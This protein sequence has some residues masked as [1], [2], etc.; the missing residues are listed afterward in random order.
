MKWIFLS[1]AA[2][3]STST[4]ATE[5]D[6][7][8]SGQPEI[9]CGP[10]S[11]LVNFNTL[12][13][14]EG[15]VYVK[16]FY[17]TPGCRTEA[18]NNRAATIS[19]P[20]SNCG[21]RRERSANPL[22][23]YVGTTVVISFHPQFV[24]KVDRAYNVRCFY[25][26]ADKTVTSQLDVS[27]ISTEIITENIPMP[28]CKYEVLSEGPN[29]APVRFA[30]IGDQVYHQWSC[31]SET[32]DVFCMTVHSCFVQ[33][34]QGTQ[35]QLLDENGCA[36]DRYLLKN[37][38][39][40]G[41]LRG[42]QES[43]VYK[44]ADKPTLFYNCQIR[45][46]LKEGGECQRTSDACQEP[47]RG[48]RSAQNEAARKTLENGAEVDVY[49]PEITILGDV[50]DDLGSASLNQE[51]DLLNNVQRTQFVPASGGRLGGIFEPETYVVSES[52]TGQICMS[53][54]GFGFLIA[55]MAIILLASLTFVAIVCLRHSKP[56]K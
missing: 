6:N 29:G 37:L 48:K 46:T 7:G 16:G 28:V 44:F 50:G 41:D 35:A 33:D 5:I 30:R 14:F 1:F 2:L 21:V 40:T 19:V 20:F 17:S 31:A 18:T 26:E 23:L 15:H 27:M 3:L 8:V 34:G 56:S 39:Y 12:N 49:T 11:I 42:G 22:G 24:T 55:V 36:Q 32:I 9:E 13:T 54:I 45:L 38:N 10:D 43:W 47:V 4:F 52:S 51:V 25:M 53:P